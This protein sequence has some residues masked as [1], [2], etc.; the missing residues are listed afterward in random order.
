M[1][2]CKMTHFQSQSQQAAAYWINNL[3]NGSLLNDNLPKWFLSN[4]KLLTNNLSKGNLPN[5]ICQN[6]S[7]NIFKVNLLDGT[8]SKW[9]VNLDKQWL[10][11]H[12]LVKRQLAEWQ[13]AKQDFHQDSTWLFR[14]QFDEKHLPKW[15]IVK[16]HWLSI[17]TSKI[18]H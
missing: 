1:A 9:M 5:A 13:F 14:Q 12:Q 11:E 15:Q 4:G 10:V 6:Q 3:S 16:E 2:K 18:L 17:K 7:Q 8:L